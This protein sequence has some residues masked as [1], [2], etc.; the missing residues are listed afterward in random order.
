MKVNI[1][2]ILLTSEDVFHVHFQPH[3]ESQLL[4]APVEGGIISRHEVQ[5]QIPSRPNDLLCLVRSEAIFL[6]Q[7]L[8]RN[9][10]HIAE[11]HV[12]R[13]VERSGASQN[14]TTS[15]RRPLLQNKA[16]VEIAKIVTQTPLPALECEFR[17]QYPFILIQFIH[18]IHLPSHAQRG[19]V[20]FN[21]ARH[22]FYSQHRS[23]TPEKFPLC[24]VDNNISHSFA[25]YSIL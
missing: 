13:D 1:K 5:F 17:A 10:P 19:D 15:V 9:R 22:L 18:V 2:T 8:R 7:S 25:L 6:R 20:Q 16:V 14:K 12:H 11:R 21:S 24:G 4:L 23:K 3:Q